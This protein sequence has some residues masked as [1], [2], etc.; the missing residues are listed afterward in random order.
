MGS[1]DQDVAWA[2]NSP[3]KTISVDAFWMDQTEI[4]NNQYRQFVYYVRDSI[5]RRML[6]KINDEFLITED[7][8]GIP[9]ILQS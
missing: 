5:A 6:V 3:T 2:I 9:L 1:N 8:F 7:Q 4:T